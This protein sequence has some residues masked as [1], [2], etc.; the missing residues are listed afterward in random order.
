VDGLT[1]LPSFE[2]GVPEIDD[3]HRKLWA[4]ANGIRDGIDALD[5]E[6]T[7]AR[8]QDFIGTA[9]KHFALEED[10]LA[11]SGYPDLEAHK[12]YHTSLLA[13]AR[14]LSLVCDA[15]MDPKKA[16]A[17]YAELVAFLI[18]DVVRGDS[19]FKSHLDYHGFVRKK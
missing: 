19:Q 15:E 5:S 12:R 6:L 17:C 8:V 11:R 1:W 18:D 13:K 14:Q 16:G 10:I 3:D 2:T 9:E 7:G 4:L